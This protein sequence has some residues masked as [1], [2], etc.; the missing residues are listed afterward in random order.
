MNE[1][2]GA[3][4][5]PAPSGSVRRRTDPSG[6]ARTHQRNWTDAARIRTNI[7]A[8]DLKW[9]HGRPCGQFNCPCGH[10]NC[11]CGRTDVRAAPDGRRTDILLSHVVNVIRLTSC[12]CGVFV[13][14]IVI[15][16]ANCPC[17]KGKVSV[18][19]P[20]GVRPAPHGRPSGQ[21]CPCGVRAT[22]VRRPCGIRADL[23]VRR[24]TDSSKKLD[25]RRTDPCGAGRIRTAP[26][27]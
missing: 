18:R 14:V 24:R 26:D 1:R 11:P 6:A 4:F 27:G 7:R 13:V 8:A 17:G 25:G 9:P 16:L 2:G 5:R 20:S 3:T 12:P 22:S 23:S 15:R 10:F 19:R 21:F